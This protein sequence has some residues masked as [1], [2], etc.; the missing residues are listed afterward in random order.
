MDPVAT[1]PGTD[2][3]FNPFVTLPRSCSTANAGQAN[4]LAIAEPGCLSSVRS[5]GVAGASG[6][7]AEGH[8]GDDA[9]GASE[10]DLRDPGKT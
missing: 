4:S 2:L 10:Q 3:D 9:G 7:S 6:K 8:C 1:A 5:A